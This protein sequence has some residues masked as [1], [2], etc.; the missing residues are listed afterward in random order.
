MAECVPKIM[1]AYQYV[2]KLIWLPDRLHMSDFSFRRLD[3]RTIPETQRKKFSTENTEDHRD[4]KTNSLQPS[5]VIILIPSF[6]K[7]K[8]LACFIRCGN[9]FSH[10]IDQDFYPLDKIGI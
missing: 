6:F 5:V 4:F 8:Q 1:G 3:L 7:S 10:F 2:G 9:L